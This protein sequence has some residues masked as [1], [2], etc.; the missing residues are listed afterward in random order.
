MDAFNVVAPF[1]HA[2]S[3]AAG[4]RRRAAARQCGGARRWE[5]FSLLADGAPLAADATMEA[6]DYFNKRHALRLD[7]ACA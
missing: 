3:P 4:R 5:C 2:A 1:S 6:A 7:P